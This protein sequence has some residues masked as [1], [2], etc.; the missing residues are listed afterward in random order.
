MAH[1]LVRLAGPQASS[2]SSLVDR[3]NAYALPVRAS[4]PAFLKDS[5][6]DSPRNGVT[7]RLL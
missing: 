5:P 4:H 1:R 7:E 6:A 3:F 2:W